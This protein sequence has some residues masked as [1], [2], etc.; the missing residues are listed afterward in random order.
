MKKRT[1]IIALLLAI[2]M[3]ASVVLVA[4]NDAPTNDGNKPGNGGNGGNNTDEG[5]HYDLT[6][7]CAEA[8]KAM[9]ESMLVDYELEND[10][11]T[12][13]FTIE[14]VGEDTSGS[15]VLEDPDVAADVF[16]FA[17]DQLGNLVKYN[18]IMAVPDAYKPQV[19]AQINEAQ[20]AA[21]YN[22][23]L[24]AFP[25]TYEN[26]FLYYNK[27]L[28]TASQVTSMENLL[29]AT[30]SAE[31]NIAMDMGDSYYTSIFLFTAG[32]RIFGEN[33]NDVN[34]V[35]FDNP[36][37]LLA[38][39][40][41]ESLGS[42]AKFKSVS[43]QD[44]A[45]AL[46]NGTVASIIS[47]PHMISTFQ[48]ALG[49]NFAVA[50]LPTIELQKGK[51]EQMI[52]FSGVKLYGV[53][54]VT[55]HPEEAAKVAAYLSNTDNQAIRLDERAFCPTDDELFADPSIASIDEVNV[56]IEQSE[57]SI[58]KPALPELKP[59]WDAMAAF[60][61]GVFTKNKKESGWSSELQAIETKVKNG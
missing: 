17:S 4:C 47:G 20:F 2:I 8:D 46:K 6:V 5:Q 15:R 49:S 52:C 40:Y 37:S 44:Q 54:R 55:S 61:N 14:T 1:V 39:K 33:G 56:V 59:Y 25:Y 57:Y 50:K 32:T 43:E 23:T 12:Y 30:T 28:L 24:Y 35:D 60:L 41:I 26:C 51:P 58:L 27:S 19:Q 7:W 53:N 36:G 21:T 13:N 3:I 42:Q 11:N 38:C 10:H 29:K 48:T 16:S 31:T 18:A 22:G 45:A 9:I 34:D